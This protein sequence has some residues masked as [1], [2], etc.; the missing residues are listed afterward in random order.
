VLFSLWKVK[1]IAWKLQKSVLTY[2]IDVIFN[3]EDESLNF[4]SMYAINL[5]LSWRVQIFIIVL[6]Y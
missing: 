4:E 3:S 6:A 1:S 2:H 5:Y